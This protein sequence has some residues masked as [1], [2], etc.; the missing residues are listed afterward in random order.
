MW[1]AGTESAARSFENGPRG[2]EKGKK[3]KKDVKIGG[4]NSK[5]Y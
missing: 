2:P 4:T 1:S 5:I 3:M